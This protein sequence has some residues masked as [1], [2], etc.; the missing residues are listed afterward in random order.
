MGRVA[1]ISG[2]GWKAQLPFKDFR[3]S[4][5]PC[6]PVAG[7]L[8]TC[9]HKGIKPEGERGEGGGRREKSNWCARGRAEFLNYLIPV[10]AQRHKVGVPVFPGDSGSSPH[11]VHLRHTHTH[12]YL[13]S[14]SA[15]R[16]G[17]RRA[18]SRDSI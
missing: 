11:Q 4:L 17:E 12:T 7:L 18:A 6:Q 9:L 14:S 3:G 10:S 8:P 2:V 1:Q 15:V 5:G 13:P 16:G